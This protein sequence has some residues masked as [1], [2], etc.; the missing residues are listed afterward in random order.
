MSTTTTHKDI[1]GRAIS[2]GDLVVVPQR[3]TG[4]DGNPRQQTIAIGVVLK[5]NQKMITVDVL[6]NRA[7][8]THFGTRMLRPLT[9]VVIDGT[10]HIT[11]FV[12][13]NS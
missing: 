1:V 7:N 11:M 2:V 3:T 8:P 4:F 5:I 9:M 12:L 13:K 10:D 6:P